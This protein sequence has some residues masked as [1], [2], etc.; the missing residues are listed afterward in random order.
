MGELLLFLLF[1]VSVIWMLR[2][3]KKKA[4]YGQTLG[5]VPSP[6]ARAEPPNPVDDTVADADPGE[7]P[8]P[9]TLGKRIGG[10]VFLSVWLTGWSFGCYFAIQERMRLSY[11]DEGYIFLTIW[12]AIAIPGWFIAAWTLFRLL[13]G[14][15]VEFNMDGDADGGD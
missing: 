15:E 2:R 9:M 3:R 14:D 6:Y 13:R 1:V 4:Y 10:I 7:D 8:E 12:L 5:D 11:G